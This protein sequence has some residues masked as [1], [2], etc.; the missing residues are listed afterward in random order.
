[1]KEK[2]HA[3]FTAEKMGNF[4]LHSRFTVLPKYG[5]SIRSTYWA[6]LE[7]VLQKFGDFF[8]KA[9]DHTGGDATL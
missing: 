7:P 1:M 2:K 9:S 8:H 5:T 3:F 4:E 6:T